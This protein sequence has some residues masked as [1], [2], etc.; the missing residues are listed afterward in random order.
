[1]S[2]INKATGKEVMKGNSATAEDIEYAVSSA[3]RAFKSFKQM[4]APQRG[5]ILIRTGKQINTAQFCVFS[6][7]LLP[8]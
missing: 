4:T 6:V 8:K 1:M 7:I 2:V 5:D 3:E